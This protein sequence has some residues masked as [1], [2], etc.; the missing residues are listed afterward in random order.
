MDRYAVIGHPISHSKSPLIH[1]A[2][3]EQTKQSLVYERIEGDVDH[4]EDEVRAF[5]ADA[6]NKGLNVTVP[7][8]ERA[9][10]MCDKLSDRAFMAEAVNTLYMHNGEL[11]GDNTDGKGLV[12]DIQENYGVRL[13]GKRV[14]LLGAGGASKG[15]M[16]PILEELPESLVIANRTFAKAEHLVGR[17]RDKATF[18]ERLPSLKACPY[19]ELDQ[20]FDVVINGTSASL[21]GALPKISSKVFAESTHV[22][23]MMYGDEGTVFNRWAKDQGAAHTM[24]GLGMLVEQAAEAFFV[25]RSV[26]PDTAKVIGDLR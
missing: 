12:R 3:S 18:S 25:W 14:L 24:D 26:M 2:F 11:V 15:V 13:K 5:F 7:F 16:L 1:A 19:D 20:V 8:K 21:S 6:H 22:Y 4:F 10:A 23:D 17:Y 9:F